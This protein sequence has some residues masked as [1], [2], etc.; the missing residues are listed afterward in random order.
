MSNEDN[1]DLGWGNPYFLLE[2]LD[3]QVKNKIDIF[4]NKYKD[5]YYQSDGGEE[6]LLDK[7][8]EITEKY[9]NRKYKHYLITNGATQAI[10]TIMRTWSESRAI[11]YCVTGKLGYPFY[12][13]IINKNIL[14]RKKVDLSSHQTDLFD[15]MV[16][17]DS[18]SNPLGEQ[19]GSVIHTINNPNV[20]WDAVYHNPIYNAQMNLM[21][22]HE[23]YI[24]SFSKLLGMTGVRVGW[25]ATDDT[26]DYERFKEDALYENATV[27]QPSQK[28]VLDT[29]N[30][31][32]LDKFTTNGK[33][34]LN[35]NREVADK[36]SSL[37]DTPVQEK[38]MFYCFQVDQKMINLFDDCNISYMMFNYNGDKFLRLNIGQTTKLLAKAVKRVLD[39]DRV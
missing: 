27:A 21:P 7:C 12:D 16:L 37:L 31:L 6:K 1:I 11:A 10:N 28:L 35:N 15:E 4:Y 36:L 19:Y 34:Y 3:S 23:V 38:G 17:V 22:N 25:I 14:W 32:D 9:T 18:P 39:K 29:I 26:Y 24:N 5:I 33:N 2:L 8:K 13:G 20:V 30:N